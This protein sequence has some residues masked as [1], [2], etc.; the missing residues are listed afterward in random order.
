MKKLQHK[1]LVNV[2]G[3]GED[4]PLPFPFDQNNLERLRWFLWNI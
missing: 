1:Q 4:V 2:V 3:G